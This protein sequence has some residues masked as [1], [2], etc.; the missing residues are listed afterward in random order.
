MRNSLKPF[1]VRTPGKPKQKRIEHGVQ[2]RFADALVPL[3]RDDVHVY[4]IPN[5]GFRLKGE[6][7]RLKAEG[8]KRGPTDLFFI[9]P[10][11]VSAW[12]E[13]KTESKGSRLSDEQEG[14]RSI[15]LRNGHLWGMYRNIEE[16]LD[17]VRAWGFLRAG[18]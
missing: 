8:V 5:G 11:G 14:F 15:C 3:L 13:T 9:A 10:K 1:R 2:S 18:K 7:N 17:Q 12:L 6:A 16:G 4:A